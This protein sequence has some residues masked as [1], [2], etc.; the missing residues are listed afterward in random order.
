MQPPTVLIRFG[1]MGVHPAMAGAANK[2]E[3]R[4]SMFLFFS[5]D[6]S[7]LTVM[8]CTHYGPQGNST[9]DAAFLVSGIDYFADS[10]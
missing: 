2:N 7:W 3:I 9:S 4:R 6:T 8:T 1:R 5:G 10:S